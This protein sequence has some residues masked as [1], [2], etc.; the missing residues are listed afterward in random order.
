MSWGELGLHVSDGQEKISC[1]DHCV[2]K[3]PFADFTSHPSPLAVAASKE[4]VLRPSTVEE[5]FSWGAARPGSRAIF[6]P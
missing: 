6:F 4:R 1:R 3:D 5:I 2:C